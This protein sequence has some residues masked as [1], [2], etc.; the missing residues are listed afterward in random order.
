MVRLSTICTIAT[1][2]VAPLAA[3]AGGYSGAPTCDELAAAGQLHAGVRCTRGTGVYQVEAAQPGTVVDGVMV[4]RQGFF[5]TLLRH[6]PAT[7]VVRGRRCPYPHR[8][9]DSVFSGGAGYVIKDT[10]R[11]RIG[12]VY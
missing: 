11:A 5:Y 7:E 2:A 9:S 1:L 12:C 8:A 10:V 6:V 3:S 4:Q